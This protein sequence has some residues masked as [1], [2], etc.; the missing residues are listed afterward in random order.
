MTKSKSI[1]STCCRW[2]QRCRYCRYF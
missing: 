2:N 1:Q